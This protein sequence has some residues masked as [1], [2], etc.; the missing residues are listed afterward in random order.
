[1]LLK[2]TSKNANTAKMVAIIKLEHV[3]S[4]AT[5]ITWRQL[6]L[7]KEIPLC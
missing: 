6:L 5:S 1:M 2:P 3:T 7:I 4:S